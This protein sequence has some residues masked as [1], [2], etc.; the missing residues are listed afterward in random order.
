MPLAAKVPDIGG[1]GATGTGERAISM[2]PVR[3]GLMQNQ[4]GDDHIVG[5][6]RRRQRP[7]IPDGKTNPR[8]RNLPGGGSE[9]ISG[10]IDPENLARVGYIEDRLGQRPG[11]AATSSHASPGDCPSQVRTTPAIG[12][13]QRPMYA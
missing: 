12:R 1:N 6:A 10:R 3:I 13:L 2:V 5:V 9:E 4:T 11:S 7:R 8:I